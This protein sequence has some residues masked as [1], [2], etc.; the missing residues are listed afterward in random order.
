MQGSHNDFSGLPLL[1]RIAL[2]MIDMSLGAVKLILIT[3][4][5]LLTGKW[6]KNHY[7][8]YHRN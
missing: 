3:P 7:D 4:F 5:D 1:V 2:A 6:L 8:D